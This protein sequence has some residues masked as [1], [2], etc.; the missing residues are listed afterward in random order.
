MLGGKYDE[1]LAKIGSILLI[2]GLKMLQPCM[3]IKTIFAIKPNDENL[4]LLWR[5]WLNK[6][7]KKGR[8]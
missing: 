8:I 6:A 2:Q 4:S 3:M 7:Y 1:E 5:I